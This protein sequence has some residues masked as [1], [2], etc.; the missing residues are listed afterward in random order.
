[1]CRTNSSASRG[2]AAARPCD[3]L[4]LRHDALPGKED[5]NGRQDREVGEQRIDLAERALTLSLHDDVADGR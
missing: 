5:Q 3:V 2:A 1:M 4:A